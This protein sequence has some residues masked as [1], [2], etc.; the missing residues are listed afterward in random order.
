VGFILFNVI[1]VLG[2]IGGAIAGV[3]LALVSR[4]SFYWTTG[5]ILGASNEVGRMLSLLIMTSM[6]IP[7]MLMF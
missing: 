5:D 3:I 7:W 2:I 1:G 6:V 4:K